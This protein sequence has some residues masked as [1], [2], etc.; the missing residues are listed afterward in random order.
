MS[1]PP[2]S[3]S[4]PPRT[5]SSRVPSGCTSQMPVLLVEPDSRTGG[6]R[7]KNKLA[8]SIHVRTRHGADVAENDSRRGS[9]AH[10]HPCG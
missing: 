3:I 1:P 10:D 2:M 6:F 8:S 7:E 5:S 4:S 9:R